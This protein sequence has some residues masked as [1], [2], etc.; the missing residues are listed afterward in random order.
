MVLHGICR[1]VQMTIQR[2]WQAGVGV[3]GSVLGRLSQE[4]AGLHVPAVIL[5]PIHTKHTP[6]YSALHYSGV[7][8]SATCYVY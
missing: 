1:G 2:G 7:H 4:L 5:P 6:D 8:R 3:G